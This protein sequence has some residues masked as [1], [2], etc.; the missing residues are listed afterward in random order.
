MPAEVADVIKVLLEARVAQHAPGVAAH[1]ED[2]AGFNVV[3]FV[4][5]EAVRIAGNAAAVDDR[6][7]VVFA[8]AL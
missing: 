8:S 1:R 7:A 6:L 4:E 3:V 2:T 5:H